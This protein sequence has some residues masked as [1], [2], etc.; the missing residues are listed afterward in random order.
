MTNFHNQ[1][2]RQRISS[3]EALGGNSTSHVLN[4]PE[5]KVIQLK[6]NVLDMVS[7]SRHSHESSDIQRHKG[8]PT[9]NKSN[10]QDDSSDSTSTGSTSQSDPSPKTNPQ[11]DE[12]PPVKNMLLSIKR[13]RHLCSD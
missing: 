9:S 5:V 7:S 10:L 1:R 8:A 13:T 12:D 11:L 2:E 3:N 6:D 4:A